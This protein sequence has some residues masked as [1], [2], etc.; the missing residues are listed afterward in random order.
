M[1]SCINNYFVQLFLL[2]L[3]TV[4]CIY[5][6]SHHYRFCQKQLYLYF[7]SIVSKNVL[8]YEELRHFVSSSSKKSGQGRVT[9]YLRICRLLYTSAQLFTQFKIINLVKISPQPTV[10]R[11]IVKHLITY[12]AVRR[13]YHNSSYCLNVG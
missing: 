6:I 13:V 2:F 8:I 12:P 5:N 11:Q 9:T 4:C 1:I 3:F 7:A 10:L